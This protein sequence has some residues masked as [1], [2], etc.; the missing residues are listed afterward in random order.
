MNK[1]IRN[2]KSE[3]R[4]KTKTPFQI[5]LYRFKKHRIAI[6]GFWML[7]VL[8]I[9][10]IF[11]DFFAPYNFDNEKRENSYHPPTKIYFAKEKSRLYFYIYRYQQKF[12]DFYR[13]IYYEDRTQI[14]PLRLFYKGDE[15]KLLGIFKTRVHLFGVSEPARIYLF[16]ADSRGRDLFSRI[17]H[18][19]RISLS[20]GLVG[21][22]ISFFLGMFMGGIA[23]YFGGRIDNFIMRLCEIIMM[24]P[25][26]YLMLTLR[27]TFPLSLSSVQIYFLIVVILSFI[28]WAGLARVIRGMALS[29]R[30]KEFVLSAR[31]SGLSNIK[32]IYRHILPNLF[33]Y[34]IVAI[35]LSIPG[36]I[37]GE[38]VLSLIG[39]GIQDP[40]ASWGNLL[41]DA[42]AISEIQRHPWILIPGLF[43]FITVS[44]FNLLGDGL[45]DA[46]DPHRTMSKL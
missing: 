10:A 42:M 18:G 40:Y 44:A 1:Q 46:F 28:G 30:E 35:T 31:V 45:R 37:L 6:W 13:R 12:D 38:S 22:S 25:G 26:F 14:Y 41:S 21:V 34:I 9:L 20:I 23:G 19:A 43:I 36:Y 17:L 5:A 16:G 32:V 7:V 2:P 4:S 24:V 3:I 8:Y 11:A 33:S 29:L 27:A 15:Y 39:L